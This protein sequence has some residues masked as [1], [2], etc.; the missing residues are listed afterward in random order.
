MITLNKKSFVSI[1]NNNHE[2]IYRPR[3]FTFLS[4][5]LFSILEVDIHPV[6]E[7]YQKHKTY[8]YVTY[9]IL[10][11]NFWIQEP[12]DFVMKCFKMFLLDYH[13]Q[14]VIRLN[15]LL[16]LLWCFTYQSFVCSHEHSRPYNHRAGARLASSQWET[17]LLCNSVFHGGKPRTHPV[18][19]IP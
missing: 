11:F 1:E 6:F 15:I 14:H 4:C 2:I 3:F 5:W 18:T 12:D 8:S 17:A 9:G 10:H 16:W 19:S 7:T 13:W